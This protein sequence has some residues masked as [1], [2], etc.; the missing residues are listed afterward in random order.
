MLVL[1]GTWRSPVA[2]Y[3][4]VV[5][6]A[7][8]NLAVPTGRPIRKNWSFFLPPPKLYL[9]GRVGSPEGPKDSFGGCL[10]Q[11]LAAM[12]ASGGFRLEADSFES[13]L[14]FYLTRHPGLDPGSQPR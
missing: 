5:G 4:G 9:R 3:I 14:L 7:S 10:Q 8:S 6:V 1:L 12:S 2:H 13:A 11:N